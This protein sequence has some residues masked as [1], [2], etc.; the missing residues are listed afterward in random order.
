MYPFL[1]TLYEANMRSYDDDIKCRNYQPQDDKVIDL[2]YDEESGK[3][4]MEV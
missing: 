2:S 1:K 4:R 3:Y